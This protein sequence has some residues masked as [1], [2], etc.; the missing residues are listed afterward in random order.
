[1][2]EPKTTFTPGPWR[3]SPQGIGGHV[4]IRSDDGDFIASV[5]KGDNDPQKANARLIAAAPDLYAAGEA[6]CAAAAEVEAMLEAGEAAPDDS[7][8]WEAIAK[9]RA[10]LRRARGEE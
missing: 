1:M 6:I 2:T 4:W 7:A 5:P 9:M 3:A 10:A 8:M